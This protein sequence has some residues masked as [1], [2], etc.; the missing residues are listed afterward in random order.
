MSESRSG[1]GGNCRES[2]RG[3]EKGREGGRIERNTL[4]KRMLVDGVKEN[5]GRTKIGKRGLKEK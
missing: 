5:H 4:G 3:M 1:K 2:E